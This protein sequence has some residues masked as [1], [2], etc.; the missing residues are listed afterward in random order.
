MHVFALAVAYLSSNMEENLEITKKNGD[1]IGRVNSLLGNLQGVSPESLL[2]VFSH[3]CCSW[4][5]T[6]NLKDPR[7]HFTQH[8]TGNYGAAQH[9]PTDTHQTVTRD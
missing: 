8:T 2:K 7:K 9:L 3:Q 4:C 6:W 5:G 1:F